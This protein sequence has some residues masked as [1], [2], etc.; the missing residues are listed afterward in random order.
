MAKMRESCEI[1]GASV[2]LLH[3]WRCGEDEAIVFQNAMG[4]LDAFLGIGHMLKDCLKYHQIKGPVLKRDMMA[5]NDYLS[6][7]TD[8]DIAF[9]DDMGGVIDDCVEISSE[10]RPSNN[11]YRRVDFMGQQLYQGFTVA[12]RT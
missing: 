12:L 11:E 6:S 10:R 3:E 2:Y 1:I 5:V 7:R 4:F 9:N 8:I